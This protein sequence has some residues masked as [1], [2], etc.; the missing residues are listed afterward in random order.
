MTPRKASLLLAS[1]VA[2]LLLQACVEYVPEE[3]A[4]RPAPPQPPSYPPQPEATPAAVPQPEPQPL[5]PNPLEP[6]LAP[7]ALYPDPLI[8]LILPAS[9]V[10]GDVTAAA[11][12][13]VQYGDPTRID[14]QPWDP[15][16]RAL[17][18]YPKVVTWMADNIAWT[19]ALGSAFS[20]SPS[21]VMDEV[22]RLRARAVAT[23][24]LTST[25]QQQVV[26]DDGQ[27]EILPAQPDEVFVPAY[28]PGV[29]YSDE[30][31]YGYNG[32]FITFGDPYPCGIW[33]SYSFDWRRHRVW[34]GNRDNWREHAG[35]SPP[36]FR[37][38]R[39]PQ[40]G[41]AWKPRPG[42][43]RSREASHPGHPGAVPTPRTLPGTPP[44]PPAHAR[45]PNAGPASPVR[46]QVPAQAPSPIQRS[47]SPA[48]Q[49]SGPTHPQGQAQAP[50][51]VQHPQSQ[52]QLPSR[53]TPP[54]ERPRIG[55][56]VQAGGTGEP[57]HTSPARSPEPEHRAQNSAPGQAQQQ[58]TATGRPGMGQPTARP[59]PGTAIHTAPAAPAHA[60]ASAPAAPAPAPA[61]APAAS[62][63][64]GDNKPQR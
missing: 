19:Q 44:P 7:I 27:I 56:P 46:S 32:P 8:A 22:Q 21:E 5:A 33:L 61:P 18:H 31:Y 57:A 2:C 12:Y 16:V 41:S 35:W 60:Q 43:D 50:N 24:A 38:D 26:N 36:R 28:D 45:R 64:S 42:A 59:A 17:A 10:P 9:T 23:G 63:S 4:Y 48:P 15:S 14:A 49:A 1:A 53:S 29:V 51:A 54:V 55:V 3:G 62:S 34:Q 11:A 47:Q 52:P 40:G 13:L 25:P 58:S 39:G 20:S 37:D 6:L 30:P